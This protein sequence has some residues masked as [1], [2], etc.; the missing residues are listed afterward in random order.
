M[1]PNA[2]RIAVVYATGQGST[3]EISE[4]IGAV[5]ANRGAGVEVADIER[6][7]DL[8]RFDAVVLGSAVHDRAFLPAA[9]AFVRHHHHQLAERK[10]WLF[11]V[12]IDAALRGPIGRRV[13]RHVPESIAALRDS[14][15][16][17]DY[18]AFAGHYERVG[19]DL[20]ARLRYRLL[21]GLRYGDLRDWT[22]IA[23]WADSIADT[24]RLAVSRTSVIHP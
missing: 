17:H 20:P 1:E 5:L 11:S 7:P 18:R 12:G 2:P 16:A 8:S 13:A 3:R 9:T 24:L 6:A 19:V 10:V 23:A 21:G 14:I 22:A 4:F 15:S